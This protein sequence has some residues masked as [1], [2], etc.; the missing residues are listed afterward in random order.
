MC[1]LQLIK[2]LQCFI[3]AQPGIISSVLH[4]KPTIAKT[5]AAAQ[6]SCASSVQLGAIPREGVTAI[7]V[8]YPYSLTSV[9]NC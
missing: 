9:M 6:G 5:S 7:T 1:F 2:D 8:G 3:H 4:F